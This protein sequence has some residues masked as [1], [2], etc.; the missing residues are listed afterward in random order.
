MDKQVRM[1]LS[2]QIIHDIN[3]Q[4][5]ILVISF[6][7]WYHLGIL[8]DSP[9]SP[10]QDIRMFHL[11]NLEVTFVIVVDKSINSFCSSL[12]YSLKLIL[13]SNW[14]CQAWQWYEQ[15]ACTTFKPR[16]TCQNI[17]FTL[18]LIKELVSS[19]DKT[20]FKI[21]SRST[22]LYF[23]FKQFQQILCITVRNTTREYDTFA[24]LD[25]QFEI[26]RYIQVLIKV[27]TTFLFLRILYASIPIWLINKFRFFVKLHIQL[28]I[29]RIHTGL[30]TILN[31]IIM[32]ASLGIL[33]SIL[34]NTT[35][36]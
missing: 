14:K 2:N 17:R 19:I 8:L 3:Q 29:T 28:R 32:S 9:Y 12:H 4:L 11:I 7:F 5:T 33:M 30:Y 21:I 35:E 6:I 25:I 27:I 24:F 26:T 13:L 22:L 20:V 36:S 34:S 10:Q 15:I 18:L 23:M 1:L 31:L 16:I